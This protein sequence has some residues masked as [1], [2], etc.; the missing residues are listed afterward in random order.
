[1]IESEEGFRIERRGKDRI[2]H[3]PQDR[4]LMVYGE[5]GKRAERYGFSIYPW[6]ITT[7]EKPFETNTNLSFIGIFRTK[8]VRGIVTRYRRAVLLD[9]VSKR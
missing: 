6:L 3:S 4:S 2:V 8:N 7:G 1:M 9:S 5:I